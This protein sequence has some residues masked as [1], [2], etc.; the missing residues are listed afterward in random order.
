MKYKYNKQNLVESLNRL[1][2]WVD[3]NFDENQSF[4]L[5]NQLEDNLIEIESQFDDIFG[6]EGY[7]H[8]I[9]AKD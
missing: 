2:E 8:S 7:N 1:S 3:N 4:A 6:T 9:L 5:F